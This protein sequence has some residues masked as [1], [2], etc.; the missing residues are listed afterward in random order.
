MPAYG[1]AIL[2]ILLV[3][4]SRGRA[5][6]GAG[7]WLSGR[8]EEAGSG[9]A[10]EGAVVRVEGPAARTVVTAEDGTWRIGPIPAG[11]YRVSVEHVGFA[12]TNRR[13]DVPFG[14]EP[15]RIRLSAR[16]LALDVLVVTGGRRVQRL[17]KRSWPPSW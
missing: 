13:I 4:P 10:V 2:V 7:E 17:P 9:S 8:V 6:T 14:E 15:L 16:P 11:L 12:E 3:V 1:V 5:Q